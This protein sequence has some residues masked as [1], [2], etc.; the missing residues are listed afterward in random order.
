[1]HGH[2]TGRVSTSDPC[3]NGEVTDLDEFEQLEET[4]SEIAVE[5]FAST[6]V[7]D[8]LL[9]IVALAEDA[10]D[11]C[12][13]AGLLVID[14]EGHPH[15]V[16]AADSLARTLD[17]DQVR[18][19]EGPCVDA[20]RTG[21]TFY[22]DDL[23]NDARWPRFGPEAA[24]HGVGCLLAYSLS[25]DRPG[26]L[27]LYGGRPS[28]FSGTDRATGQLFAT[29]ARLALNAAEVQAA[30][31]LAHARLTE[32]LRTR[33]LIGQAQGILMERERITADQAFEQL[34]RA[35]QHLNVKLREVAATL[36]ERGEA[37]DA[38]PHPRTE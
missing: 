37:P 15:T 26:A 29:L 19:G 5:L 21:T 4:F 11:G 1:M 16:A 34:R 33:E 23:A 13:T 24:R 17:D 2:P 28:A 31:H 14:D 7:A 36:V 20:A 27:N 12:L 9:R 3:S 32:A 8:T 6:T 22:A 30:D 38:V 18:L 10:V 25:A 35:S